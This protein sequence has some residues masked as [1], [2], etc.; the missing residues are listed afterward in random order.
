MRNYLINQ[1]RRELRYGGRFIVLTL[2]ILHLILNK[3]IVGH[4]KHKIVDKGK[5]VAIIGRT[6]LLILAFITIF[7]VLEPG[8]SQ[9][10]KWSLLLFVVLV[11]GFEAMIDWKYLRNTNQYMVSLILLVVA[12]SLVSVLI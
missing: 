8:E 3:L 2:S 10:Y 1:R 12:V 9:A 6:F 11:Y 5:K 4:Q 7:Y